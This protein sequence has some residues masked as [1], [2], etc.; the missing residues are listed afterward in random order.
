MCFLRNHFWDHNIDHL[1][2]LKLTPSYPLESLVNGTIIT[3]TNSFSRAGVFLHGTPQ[4][5]IALK[6]LAKNIN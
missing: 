3:H 1:L 4:I 2:Q 6:R 5:R